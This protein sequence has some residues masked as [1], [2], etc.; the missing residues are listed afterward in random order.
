MQ[1]DDDIPSVKDVMAANKVNKKSRRRMKILKRTKQALKVK[2]CFM[3]LL[4]LLL[5]KNLEIHIFF[6][7]M[8][9]FYITD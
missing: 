3:V 9:Y 5:R 1:K 7:M 6:Y 2:I 4:L 8:V